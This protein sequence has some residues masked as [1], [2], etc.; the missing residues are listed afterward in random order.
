MGNLT[1]HDYIN[2]NSSYL[3]IILIFIYAFYIQIYGEIGPGGGFQGGILLASGFILHALVFNY[4]ETLKIIKF[5]VLRIL[6]ATGVLIYF[7]TGTIS[8]FFGRNFLNYDIIFPSNRHLAQAIGVF[9]VEI[10]V[11]MTV[12]STMLIIFFSFCIFKNDTKNFIE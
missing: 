4:I 10:G 6:T 8:L 5:S 12:F 1:M 3:L 2:K 7:G 9:C 11:G